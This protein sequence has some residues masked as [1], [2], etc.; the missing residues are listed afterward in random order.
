MIKAAQYRVFAQECK[1][2][3]KTMSGQNRAKLLK[4]AE[5]WEKVA[6]EIEKG[7]PEEV[8]LPC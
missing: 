8:V 1:D 4:I 2:L 5:A 6:A 7:D 3:A